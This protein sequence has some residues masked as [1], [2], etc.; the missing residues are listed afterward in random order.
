M[1][2]DSLTLTRRSLPQRGM[3]SWPSAVCSIRTSST[4][5]GRWREGEFAVGLKAIN[6]QSGKDAGV[7]IAVHNFGA[8]DLLEIKPKSGE[9][10]LLPFNDDHVPNV[11]EDGVRVI[12]FEDEIG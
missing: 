10:Y 4:G 3:P 8:G 6:A 5:E 1:A 12:P 9:T 7:I 11:N 2:D